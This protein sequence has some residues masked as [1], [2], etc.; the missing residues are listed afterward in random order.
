MTRARLATSVVAVA[1]C[2]LVV[3]LTVRA[4]GEPS[5]AATSPAASSTPIPSPVLLAPSTEPLYSAPLLAPAQDVLA[6][7]D[8]LA[9]STYAWLADLL[10][11]RY[12]SWDAVVGRSTQ[13]AR[14]ALERAAAAGDVPPVILVSSGTND[15]DARTLEAEARRI[16]EI[17]GPKRCVVW[18]DVVRPD[19]YGDGMAAANDAL[20]RAWDGHPNVV[21]VSWTTIVEEH[22]DWLTVDGIHPREPGNVAR[23]EAFA[24]AVLACSPLDPSA[25][26]AAQQYLP[27]SAFLAP[28]GATVPGVAPNAPGSAPAPSPP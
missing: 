1:A 22:P 28:G 6:L 18:A 23:A 11:D 4:A 2:A 10:P 3:G 19:A 26:V 8:S 24:D 16:L 27:P 13:Q 15:P 14:I 9:L 12:V 5:A 20:A 21:P 7:G 25:P 17:A